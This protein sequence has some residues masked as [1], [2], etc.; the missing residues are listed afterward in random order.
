MGKK[1]IAPKS[2]ARLYFPTCFLKPWT[3]KSWVIKRQDGLGL[4]PLSPHPSLGN[5]NFPR[6]EKM[7]EFSNV[8]GGGCGESRS[9][10]VFVFHHLKCVYRI[11]T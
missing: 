11:E 8:L 7:L 2:R 9:R 4:I 10:R 1:L 5:V 3:K 6:T